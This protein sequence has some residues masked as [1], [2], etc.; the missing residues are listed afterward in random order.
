MKFP[1]NEPI[2]QNV[3]PNENYILEWPWKSP[4]HWAF[5]VLTYPYNH[6]SM[7]T[8]IKK[9]TW[10]LHYFHILSFLLLQSL[11]LSHTNTQ[12][13]INSN[14]LSLSQHKYTNF[15]FLFKSANNNCA[16]THLPHTHKNHQKKTKKNLLFNKN[17]CFS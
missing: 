9:S 8:K 1:K 16:C 5:K 13:F 12:N 7:R 2:V 6:P 10:D 17:S 3:R 11:F 14:N 15:L 4:C